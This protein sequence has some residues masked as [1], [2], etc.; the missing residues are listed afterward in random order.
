MRLNA[1]FKWPNKQKI[2]MNRK[3]T[4]ENFPGWRSSKLKSCSTRCNQRIQLCFKREKHM[5]K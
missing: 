1:G 4:E 5:K 3:V 2:I